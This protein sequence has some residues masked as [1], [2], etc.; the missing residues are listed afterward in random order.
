M[1]TKTIPSDVVISF[2]RVTSIV[3]IVDPDND[4][5]LIASTDAQFTVPNGT[6]DS[7]YAAALNNGVGVGVDTNGTI[8]QE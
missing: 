5:L 4:T 8:L 3:P 1:K 7:S 6:L 2:S